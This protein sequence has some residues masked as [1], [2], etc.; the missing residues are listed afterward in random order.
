M[1]LIVNHVAKFPRKSKEVEVA[2]AL[3]RSGV[4]GS[5]HGRTEVLRVGLDRL[6]IAGLN[7]GILVHG[8]VAVCCRV[9]V[10]VSMS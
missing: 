1:E 5:R 10:G 4:C 2:S 6:S 3:S 9:A 7:C 8:A